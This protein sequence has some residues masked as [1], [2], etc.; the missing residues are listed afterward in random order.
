MDIICRPQE[1]QRQR[2]IYRQFL[3]QNRER[4][5]PFNILSDKQFKLAFRLSKPICGYVI[6]LLRPQVYVNKL[7]TFSSLN[8]EG[9]IICQ[10]HE[11]F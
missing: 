7:N 1:A 8:D 11:I 10:I 5:D 2:I 3:R 4:N 6:G 9:K